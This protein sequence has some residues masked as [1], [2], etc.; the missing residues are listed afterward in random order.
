MAVG[1]TLAA[2]G[3]VVLLVGLP[4]TG[5]AAS[6]NGT[7][8]STG[9]LAL[10]ISGTDPNG[11]GLR[12]AMDGNFS[13]LVDGLPIN[14]SAKST[15]L[16]AINAQESG[17]AGAIL[18]GNRD[19]SVEANEVTMFETLL[20][21][22]T[23]FFPSSSLT[24]AAAVLLTLDGHA[25][26]GSHLGAI[27]FTGAI[28]PDRSGAPIGISVAVTYDFSTSGDSHVLTLGTNLSGLALGAS[29]IVPSI[30]INLTFPSGTTVTS[31]SGFSSQTTD[32]DALGW[33]SPTVDGTFAPADASNVTV[34]YGPAFPL[35]DALLI[36][37]PLVILGCVAAFL[38]L[39]RRRRRRT[40]AP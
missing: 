37:I 35:G 31:T 26:T 12:Y 34:A 18:F 13:P 15:L 5:R 21:D 25:P 23:Q 9:S 17:L 32:S 1:R 28:G 33:S 30:D 20:Q 27:D 14:A 38:L 11:S 7:V 24:P 10:T 40:T 29:L 16:A 39:R 8:S 3:L 36:G 2:V 19:G 4:S 6:V 22:A